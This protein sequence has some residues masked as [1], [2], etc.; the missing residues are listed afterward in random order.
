[1]SAPS[2]L[3][4]IMACSS[5]ALA[6]AV[7]A[8]NASRTGESAQD[9][10]FDAPDR[11]AFPRVL[12][13]LERRC[14]TLDCHGDPGRNMR[15]YTGSGLRLGKMDIPGESAT[16]DAEYNASYWSVVGLEPEIMSAVVADGGER[17][18]R[19]TMVRKARGTEYHK[20]GAILEIGEPA[21][22]CL[23]SWLASKLDEEACK[24]A[25]DFNAPDV[26]AGSS[27]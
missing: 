9:A 13:A 27:P 4:L 18:E 23:T 1:M 10:P 16:T 5:F 11:L 12:D 19:L 6:A 15:L 7:A 22:R 24:T 8:C 2:R 25:A 14:G 26:D 17:P 20:P 21:D 3:A